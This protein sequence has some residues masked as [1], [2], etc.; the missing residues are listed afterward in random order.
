MKDIFLNFPRNNYWSSMKYFFKAI[1]LKQK[2]DVV[3][4][5]LNHF[6]RG[7]NAKNNFFQPFKDSCKKHNINYII[8]EE[9]DLKGAFNMYPRNKGA[10]PLDFITLL[11]V[12]L[13]K[14]FSQRNLNYTMYD[15][16]YKREVLISKILKLLFFRKF[17]SNIYIVLAHNNVTLWR[18]IN[19]NSFIIDYQHGMIWNG[20]DGTLIDSKPSKIKVLNDVISMVYG[21]SF[22]DLL[23]QEDKTNF[24]TEKNVIDIGFFQKVP[25]LTKKINNKTILYTLQ[26]V[27]MES[28]FEYYKMIQNIIYDNKEF[29][30]KNGYKIL[31]KN[32]PRYDRN[33]KLLFDANLSFLSFIEDNILIEN[34]VDDIAIHI[35]SK[36]TAAFDVALRGIPTIF[37]DMLEARSPSEMFIR[38]YNYPLNNFIITETKQ[39]EKILVRL[40]NQ[41]YFEET[42]FRVYNWARSFYQDFD[43]SK[44]LKL[45]NKGEKSDAN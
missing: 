5:A 33:D 32:H 21:K 1:F 16:Y 13:R 18:V 10:I 15:N 28:T 20:H 44:F 30:Q 37:I 34:I 43:E 23:F 42:S 27:D 25:A 38:Q 45:L 11:Q 2:C 29:F 6:N 24:Y 4:V 12:I 19:P 40:E 17:K 9:T 36:S 41:N 26:N 31:F 14:L 35:T 3:F 7:E 22:Q 8:F 39:V